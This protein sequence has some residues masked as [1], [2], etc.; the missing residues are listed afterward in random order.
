MK[1]VAS[2]LPNTIDGF[3]HL[4]PT[5]VI[6]TSVLSRLPR[7]GKEAGVVATTAQDELVVTAARDCYRVRL[8]D[9]RVLSVH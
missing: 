5:A 7:N 9:S 6:Y 3:F 2:L 4:A 1:K 8:D